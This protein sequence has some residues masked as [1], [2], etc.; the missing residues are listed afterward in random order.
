[1]KT[2]HFKKIILSSVLLGSSQVSWAACDQTLSPGANLASAISSAANGSTI[3]LNSGDYGSVDL[4][5]MARTGYVT[6]TSLNGTGAI[7]SPSI[8]NSDYIRFDRM[9]LTSMLINNGSTN[10]QIVNSTFVPY[11]PGLAVVS[12]SKTLIDNVDFTNVNNQTWSGRLSLNAASYTTVTNSKFVGV[13][14][15]V[16]GIM[17]VGLASNNTI[18]P[19]NL[20]SGILQ[21]LCSV[22][23]PGSHCDAI[24]DFG[25]GPGNLITGNYFVNGDTFIMMPDGS[26]NVTI[27]NNVFDGSSVNYAGKIQMGSAN[28]PRFEHNTVINTNAGFNSK[29]GN[30]ATT[31]AIVKNNILIGGEF[32]ISYGNG[33][34]NCTFTRN[35]FDLIGNSTGTINL[36]GNPTYV[37]GAKPT[38]L[39]GFQLT[40]SSLGYKAA[41][42]GNDTGVV[43]TGT[44]TTAPPAAPTNLRAN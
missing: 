14:I 22:S 27:T 3:C 41:L 21:A 8:N 13:G 25:G 6:L 1:M 40:S 43:F 39:A 36:I 4:S 9:T 30:A 15:G 23:S 7:L 29:S 44:T 20:F 35:L 19:N 31:N 10:I 33:C 16:D 5:N 38:N 37:G 42:D 18:G 34:S 32:D 12:S 24:Q 2:Y 11:K 17:I 28:N 26:D